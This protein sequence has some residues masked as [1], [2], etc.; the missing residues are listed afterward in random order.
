MGGLTRHSAA[1]PHDVIERAAPRT[2]ASAAHPA[3]AAHRRHRRRP[4]RARRPSIAETLRLAAGSDLMLVGIGTAVGE[5]SLVSSGMIDAADVEAVRRAGGAGEM[6][7][8]FFDAQGRPVVTDLARRTVTVPLESLRGRRIVA[9]A[10][11]TVKVEAIRAVLASGL[12]SGL[13]TDER[14]ARALAEP[15]RASRDVTEPAQ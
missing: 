8:H 14:T 10:G 13:I 11:G 5:A 4:R 15:H 12:L 2:G 3:G 7:G 1:N 6:L 9:L